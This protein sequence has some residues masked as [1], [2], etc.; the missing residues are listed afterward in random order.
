MGGR[1][2]VWFS[3]GDTLVYPGYGVGVVQNI[4]ERTIGEAPRLFCVLSFKE[5]ENE[6]KVMIPM[7]NVHEVRLRPLSDSRRVQEALAFLSNGEPEIVPSWRDRFAMHGDMLAAG[8]LMS[9]V[10]VLKAL[11][12]LN[13]KKPLSF[14]EKKMYQ[15]AMLLITSEVCEVLKSPRQQ[16]EADILSR[17]S[18][19]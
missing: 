18:K 5:T 14:R 2:R 8:D 19:N 17:L 11:Y 4:E 12:I 13:A 9:V 6:S 3:V 7:D 15:K 16:V 1:D 10:K